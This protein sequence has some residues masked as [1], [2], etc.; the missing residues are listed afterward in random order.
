MGGR[1]ESEKRGPTTTA[2]ARKFAIVDTFEPRGPTPT[3]LTTISAT[4]RVRNWNGAS[5]MGKIARINRAGFYP[6]DKAGD[7]HGGEIVGEL[8]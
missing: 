5:N 4:D 1:R 2:V 7:R 3:R 8:L 6:D